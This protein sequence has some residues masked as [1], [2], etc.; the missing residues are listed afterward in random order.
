MAAASLAQAVRSNWSAS[1]L[2]ADAAISAAKADPTA[3]K[4]HRAARSVCLIFMIIYV[5]FCVLLRRI[6][7]VKA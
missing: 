7:V 2:M 4:P 5:S 1:G 6:S 3:K